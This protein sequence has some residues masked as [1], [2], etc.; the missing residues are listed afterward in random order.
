V[1]C[2]FLPVNFEEVYA[3]FDAS[4]ANLD[5]GQYCAPYNRRGQGGVSRGPFC[6]D[7]RQAVPTVY[8]EEFEYL[9]EHTDLW[10]PWQG[11]TL[12]E[13]LRVQDET[14][15]SMLLVECLGYQQCQRPFRSF[16]CRAFP[17]FPY[18]TRD[19]W[20]I[21]MTYYWQYENVCWVISNLQVVTTQYRQ[22][23]FAAFDEL[24]E[25]YPQEREGYRLLSSSMR[26]VFSRWG[27]SVPVLHRNGNAYKVTPKNGRLRRVEAE[28]FPKHGVY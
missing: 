13:T 4:L 22:Q 17:F 2:Q 23:F 7:T 14:P 25:C 27:R 3:H 18:I 24:F 8:P 1:N 10:H 21:G 19:D 12:A 26:R 16:T 9:Q 28:S 15:G 20:F 6:C 5:C 11:R